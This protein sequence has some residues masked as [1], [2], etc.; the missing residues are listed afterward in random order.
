M[1]TEL[2][3][4]FSLESIKDQL[5]V[6]VKELNTVHYVHIGKDDDCWFCLII[7]DEDENI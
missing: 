2:I 6:L 5:N 4:G 1:T 3:Y 7:T